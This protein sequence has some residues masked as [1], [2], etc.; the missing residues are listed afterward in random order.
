MKLTHLSKTGSIKMVGVSG[1]AITRRQAKAFARVIMK[2]ATFKAITAGKVKKG[3]VL[4][5]ARLAGI[6]ASKE[7][8]RLIPL[9]HPIA[10]TDIQ[11]DFKLV[12]PNKVEIYT[13]VEALDRTGVEMEALCAASAAALTIYDMCKAVDRSMRI[14]DVKLLE[15][16]GGRSGHYRA[17]DYTD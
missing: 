8:H 17:T 1:K 12:R 9:C 3:N 13:F 5:T 14:T 6:M 11:V 15:K 10:I 7:T 4:E 16:S 2:S